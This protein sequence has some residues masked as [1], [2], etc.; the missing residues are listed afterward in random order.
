M[1]KVNKQ[2]G[3]TLIE[4]ITS[5]AIF[6]VVMTISMGSILGVFEANRVSRSQRSVMS[7][8][9]LVVESM[10]KEMRYGT[11][12]NCGGD[13]ASFPQNCAWGERQISFKSSDNEQYTYRQNGTKIERKIGSG[14]FVEL[15][16]PEVVIDN[17]TFYVFGAGTDNSLHP[18]V[19]ILVKGRG[20][21]GKIES[22]FTL[23]TMVS[24]RMLE[25]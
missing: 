17:L 25:S 6:A 4:L 21:S 19:I 16:S 7:N 18:K 1:R 14:N 15:T 24:Q 8:L 20:V 3:F 10:S 12:Y 22:A 23:Q 13:N 11:N 5:L 9:N 2:S